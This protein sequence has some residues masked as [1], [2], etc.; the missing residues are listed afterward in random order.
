MNLPNAITIARILMVPAFVY[1]SYGDTA[2]S[3]VVSFVI[4]LVAS[5]SDSLDGYLARRKGIVSRLGEFLD[6]LADK[7]LV[8][9]ALFVLVDTRSF[10]V[11]H[12]A[13]IGG[14]EIVVQIYRTR[15]VHG[16]GTLP[17]SKMGK[18]KTVTQII[19]VCWWLLPWERTNALHWIWLGLVLVTTFWSAIEYFVKRQ[20]RIEGVAS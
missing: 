13:L 11:W 10:P 14:R 1:F 9:A 5:L 16:G 4:F 12:A 6:P 8:G 17:A 15:I 3:A 20:A 7:L 2:S 18:A 19:M